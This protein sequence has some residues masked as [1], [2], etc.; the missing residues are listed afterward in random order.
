[1]KKIIQTAGRDALGN[2]APDF[3]H[4]NDDVL[5]GEVKNVTYRDI[6]R[7]SEWVEKQLRHYHIYINKRVKDYLD[8]QED[9]QYQ[10]DLARGI[11]DESERLAIWE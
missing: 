8:Q 4:F 11:C 7:V 1:M 2:F 3:A 9:K 5:F 6:T 10:I